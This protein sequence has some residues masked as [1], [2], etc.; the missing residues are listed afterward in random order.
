[1]G[2]TSNRYDYLAWESISNAIVTRMDKEKE[3]SDEMQ[4]YGPLKRSS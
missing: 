2:Y 4:L 3:L 1:M